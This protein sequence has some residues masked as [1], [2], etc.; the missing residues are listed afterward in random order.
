MEEGNAKAPKESCADLIKVFTK[1]SDEPMVVG[2]EDPIMLPDLCGVVDLKKTPQEET[3]IS[4]TVEAINVIRQ[5]LK[6]EPRLF[7]LERV[8]VLSPEE[9]Y[10]KVVPTRF[11]GKALYGHVYLLRNESPV[12][13]QA[14]LAHELTHA[15]SFSWLE[16]HHDGAEAWPGERWPPVCSRRT[17]LALIDPSYGTWLPHFHGLNEGVTESVALMA[18]GI[19][20]NRS[21]VLGEQ[22]KQRIVRWMS[23]P[24]LVKFIDELVLLVA[25]EGDSVPVWSVL[26]KDLFAGADEF[27]KLLEVKLPGATERLRRTGARPPEL[28]AAAVDL[29]LDGLSVYIAKYCK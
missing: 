18:R 28:L 8:H 1:R 7:S 17:G 11:A 21:K 25:G 15:L 27:L 22:E 13:F 3:Q 26:A 20:S 6:L 14:I 16:L 4:E 9:M 10:S 2:R 12:D 23:S 5:R 24:P 29:G 19:L